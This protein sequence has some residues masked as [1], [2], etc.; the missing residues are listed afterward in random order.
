MMWGSREGAKIII[1]LCKTCEVGSMLAFWKWD[2]R[3]IFKRHSFQLITDRM[4]IFRY[5]LGYTQRG[6]E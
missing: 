1:Y 4:D 2:L 3:N 5:T 6:D